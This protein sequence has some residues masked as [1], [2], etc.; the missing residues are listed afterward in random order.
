[1]KAALVAQFTPP[2]FLKAF[3]DKGYKGTI[4]SAFSFSSS[5]TTFSS[6]YNKVSFSN[7]SNL[8]GFSQ[9]AFSTAKDFKLTSLALALNAN[10]LGASAYELNSTSLALASDAK[11]LNATANELAANANELNLSA[12]ELTVS[13]K[14]V[15]DFFAQN[16]T[17]VNKNKQLT[18][19]KTINY[20]QNSK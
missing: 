5:N 6:L 4:F 11:E 2:Y 17:E 12:N 13:A 3:I 16:R 1:L 7:L 14:E 19:L 15:S 18:N 10:E 8:E 9:T 20:G